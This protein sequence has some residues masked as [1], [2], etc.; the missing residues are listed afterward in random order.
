MGRCLRGPSRSPLRYW[1]CIT[2]TSSQPVA[3]WISS[4]HSRYSTSSTCARPGRLCCCQLLPNVVGWGGCAPATGRHSL[5][6]QTGW[7]AAPARGSRLSLFDSRRAV[8]VGTDEAVRCEGRA[9]RSLAGAGIEDGHFSRLPAVCRA[10]RH[11]PAA[12][13]RGGEVDGRGHGRRRAVRR[14]R[15]GPA[16]YSTILGSGPMA[17]PTPRRRVDWGTTPTDLSYYQ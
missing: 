15:H 5:S 17:T 13:A 8:G 7:A 16:P 11:A 2:R 14:L 1:C 10:P 6:P 3:R 4:A 12:V 9:K